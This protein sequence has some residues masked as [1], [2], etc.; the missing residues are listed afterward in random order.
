MF[1][2]L[3]MITANVAVKSEASPKTPTEKRRQR[4]ELATEGLL[5]TLFKSGATK[6]KE[7][8]ASAIQRLDALKAKAT[9]DLLWHKERIR[10]NLEEFSKHM[11]EISTDLKGSTPDKAAFSKYTLPEYLVYFSV[12]Q[13]DVSIHAEVLNC[14]KQV[15][16]GSDPQEA[17]KKLRSSLKYVC[18]DELDDEKMTDE[19]G[20][21]TAAAAGYTENFIPWAIALVASETSAA[22]A[23][24][25]ESENVLGFIDRQKA[26]LKPDD[27]PE[28]IGNVLKLCHD[29]E[30]AIQ[31]ALYGVGTDKRYREIVTVAT[32]IA[33]DCYK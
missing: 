2:S 20:D 31:L 22:N 16:H 23:M 26:N 4:L 24:I 17:Y 25:A 19:D 30:W 27:S 5:G 11:K 9:K 1:E 14:V 10:K 6:Q 12:I 7:R 13:R 8:I 28:K 33:G 21:T 15:L 3:L 29:V 18:W 32:H